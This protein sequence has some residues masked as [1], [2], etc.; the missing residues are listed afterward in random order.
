LPFEQARYSSQRLK[1]WSRFAGMLAL[2]SRLAHD[3]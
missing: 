2:S 3:D 1:L